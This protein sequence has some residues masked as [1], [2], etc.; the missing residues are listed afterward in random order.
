MDTDMQHGHDI[1]KDMGMQHEHGHGHAE[2][3][4]TWTFSIDAH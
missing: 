2:E 1:K 3:K 4:L